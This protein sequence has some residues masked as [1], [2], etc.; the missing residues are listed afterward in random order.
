MT[1]Y[2]QGAASLDELCAEV[3][4]A[5]EGN[6]NEATTRLR[7]IDKLLMDVL[8]WPADQINCEEYHEGGFLDYVV[9]APQSRLVLEAKRTGLHFEVPAGTDSG[10]LSLRQFAAYSPTNQKAVDQVLA[11]CQH[12]GIPIAVLCNGVQ[13]VAF[14]G[15]RS[16]GVAP[17]EGDAVLYK[18]LADARQMFVGLWDQLSL[19]GVES[20]AL[21]RQL[22]SARTLAVPPAPLSASIHQY[23][24][25]RIG[26]AMETDLS[27]LGDLF[28]QDVVNDE[29]V[30]EDFLANCYCS[31]GALSQYAAVSKEILKSRYASLRDQVQVTDARGRKGPSKELESSLIAGSL[32]TR[33][34]VLLGDVGVGKSIFLKHLFRLEAKDILSDTVVFYID[35]LK[36][37]GLNVDVSSHIVEAVRRELERSR[38]ID[39]EEDAIV[40]AIYNAEIN[41]FRK[42]VSGPLQV[43]DPAEYRRREIDMLESHLRKPLEHVRRTLEFLRASRG[44]SFV[45]ALDNVDQHDVGFQDRLFVVAHSLAAEWPAT[46]FL[47]LRPDTFHQSR[48]SGAL[49]AYQP[50]VFTVSP[51]RSDLVIAKRLQFAAK[52]LKEDGRLPGFPV[53]LTIDSTTLLVYISVLTKAFTENQKLISVVDNLSSGNARKALDFIST[54]VGSGYVQTSRILDLAASGATYF[55]PPHEFLRAILFQDHKYYDPETSPVPNLLWISTRSA[56]EHFLLPVL[57]ATVQQLGKGEQNGFVSKSRLYSSIQALGYAPTDIDIHFQRAVE[58]DLLEV[59]DPEDPQAVVRPTA[60]GAY[61]YQTL[62]SDFAYLDAVVVDTPVLNPA[63]RARIRDVQPIEERIERVE[64][65]LDY[66]DESWPFGNE[67]MTFSWPAA[68]AAADAELQRVKQG[69]ARASTR[70]P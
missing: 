26:S 20:G 22:A 34:I 57:L 18:S 8:G 2:D 60:A 37:S 63:F 50:R 30:T 25:Y 28:I 38:S 43:D 64:I 67:A 69:A 5:S 56:Q 4:V 41:R 59:S 23:P 65:F 68:R 7:I 10:T 17:R 15:S 48:R 24:G 46:V 6:E 40:R 32:T 27:I 33:P 12:A 44:L 35:F 31:S 16:D 9:G 13:I 52:R 3:E 47:T 42:G 14:L 21:L 58:A 70:R 53:G 39:L 11:Y 45:I 49:A 29:T 36:H 61:M 19:P 51:P 55:V 62:I 1:L 54:F 66:L